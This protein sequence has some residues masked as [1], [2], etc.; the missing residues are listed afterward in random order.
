[1]ATQPLPSRGAHRPAHMRNQ[2]WLLNPY[3]LGGPWRGKMAGYIARAVSA[4]PDAQHGGPRP[5]A[6]GQNQR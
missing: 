2:K 3:R 5:S 4:V 1:M 6:R